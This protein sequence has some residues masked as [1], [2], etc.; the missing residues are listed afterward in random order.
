MSKDAFA[1]IRNTEL[2]LQWLENCCSRPLGYGTRIKSSL[3][4][5]FRCSDFHNS[6]SHC[7]IVSRCG[8]IYKAF[9]P[10]H[11]LTLC[12]YLRKLFLGFRSNYKLFHLFLGFISYYNLWHLA[13]VLFASQTKY[14]NYSKTG[15]PNAGHPNS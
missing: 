6:D 5:C 10:Q 15:H 3:F 2:P 9:Y 14:S 11:N 1:G 8:T 7:I 12:A 13:Q 4:R